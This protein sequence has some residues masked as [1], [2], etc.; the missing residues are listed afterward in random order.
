[1]PITRPCGLILFVATQSSDDFVT[2]IPIRKCYKMLRNAN[3]CAR[4]T[5]A[6]FHV[7][8]FGIKDLC[9]V[10]IKS[11]P[12]HRKTSTNVYRENDEEIQFLLGILYA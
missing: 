3:I 12:N 10:A 4:L 8:S 9:V 2:L 1:M 6:A 5:T 7:M 11:A